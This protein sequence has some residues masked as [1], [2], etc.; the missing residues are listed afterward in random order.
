MKCELPLVT[1]VVS[2]LVTRLTV[3]RNAPLPRRGRSKGRDRGAVRFNGQSQSRIKYT[4]KRHIDRGPDLIKPRLVLNST[5][6]VASEGSKNMH[7]SKMCAIF[8]KYNISY[9]RYGVSLCFNGLCPRR[10]MVSGAAVPP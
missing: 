6:A 4:A 2:A 10:N 3:S 9:R 5:V 1:P 8:K 7:V